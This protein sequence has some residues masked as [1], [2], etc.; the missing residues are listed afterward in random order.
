MP[1]I[2]LI[3]D[4]P[5]LGP[6]LKTGLEFAG[7][8]VT[9]AVTGPQGLSLAAKTDS[10]LIV[11]DLM[12]PYLNGISVLRSVRERRIETPVIILTAKG[13]EYDKL[14]GFQHGC[15]DYITKPFSLKELI[16][17]IRAVLRRTGWIETRSIVNSNGITID[18][19]SREALKNGK[20]VALTKREFDL[21]YVL[22]SRPNQALSRDY[23]INEV[24]GEDSNVANRAIDAR[25][26]SLRR[27]VEDDSDNP[28]II[29]TVYKVGYKWVVERERG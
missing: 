27:K 7:F 13:A 16:A 25:I 28:E 10:Q 23:L 3:E 8:R 2:L 11:L 19:D 12:L 15:D 5:K 18:P 20:P 22:A 6:W 24:W 4:D 1:N 14:E 26:V 29:A 17:R 21:L 9:L